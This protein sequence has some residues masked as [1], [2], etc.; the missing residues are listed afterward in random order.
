MTGLSLFY[1]VFLPWLPGRDGLYKGVP[2][3]ALTLAGTLAY[4]AALAPAPALTLANRCLGLGFLAFFV[5]GEFQGMS[6][7]MR[8]EQGNWGIEAAVGA[9]VL[10][11]YLA[12]PRV[13]GL[14]GW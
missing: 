4:S 7:L 5:S 14:W 11:V 9:I 2:M 6:P 13:A 12:L 3:V 1:G 10:V 8:G